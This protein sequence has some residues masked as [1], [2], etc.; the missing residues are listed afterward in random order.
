MID[1]LR[2]GGGQIFIYSSSQTVKKSVSRTRTYEYLPPPPQLSI[3]RRP[4]PDNI[5]F[6]AFSQK[7]RSLI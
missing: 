6:D 2:G 1:N 5:N 4:W 3:F 7:D